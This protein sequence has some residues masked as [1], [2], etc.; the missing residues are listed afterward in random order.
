L[1]SIKE[2]I[3]QG[4][5]WAAR[6]GP[7]CDE[8]IR[9]VKFRLTDATIADQVRST[10]SMIDKFS[11]VFF[12]S[13]MRPLFQAMLRSGGQIIPTARRVAYSSFLLA[14]PRLMEPI[15]FTEIQAPA[16]AIKAIYNVLQRRRGHVTAEVPMP[17]T[18]LFS[19]H[20]YLPAIESFGFETDLRTHT[21][22]QAFC[23]SLFDH[24]AV[25]PGDPLDKSI[26]VRPLE[27]APVGSLARDFMV[28]TRRRKVSFFI[29]LLCL[30]YAIFWR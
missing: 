13:L 15:L 5:Q 12:I 28:K 19:V 6:E 20:A 4:F 18:P 21:L 9:N 11:R 27:P 1:Y 26:V 3:V 14:T 25:V 30:M 22:G 10:A 23:L 24:W 29:V 17:G 16:D 8:P 2:S 7:L